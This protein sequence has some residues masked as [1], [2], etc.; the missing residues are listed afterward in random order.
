MAQ[1]FAN[2]GFSYLY[3]MIFIVGS[4]PKTQQFRCTTVKHC[5]HCNNDS[6]WVLQKQQQFI[7]LFFLPVIPLKTTYRYTCPICGN[8]EFMDFDTFEQK[9]QSEST[10]L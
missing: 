8:T 2:S 7:S 1:V 5:F 6:H 4:H 9:V 10:P 3:T